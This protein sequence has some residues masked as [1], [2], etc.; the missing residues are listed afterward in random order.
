MQKRT[1]L[2]VA[3]R[4][5]GR[6]VIIVCWVRV[7]GEG[8]GRRGPLT[9]LELEKLAVLLGPC[10]PHFLLFAA[11][12]ELGYE[13]WLALISG[14][15]TQAAAEVDVGEAGDLGAGLPDAGDGVQQG[16]YIAVDHL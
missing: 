12:M 9:V 1:A 7:G 3:L 6:S 16:R 10:Q 8:T 15:S 11:F 5:R 2:I 13:A 4:S 14:T